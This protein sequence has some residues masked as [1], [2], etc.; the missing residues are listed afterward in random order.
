M[1]N[2]T[3]KDTVMISNVVVL[4]DTGPELLTI[5]V[6]EGRQFPIEQRFGRMSVIMT[7]HE[8][9]RHARAIINAVNTIPKPVVMG[10]KSF[11]WR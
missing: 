1:K 9:L 7:P 2:L 4:A 6:W 10:M 11:T 3:S 8:A 5:S